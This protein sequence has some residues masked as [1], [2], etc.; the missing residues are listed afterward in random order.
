MKKHIAILYALL[1]LAA[2]SAFGQVSL[3]I[4]GKAVQ[5]ASITITTDTV[6]PPP[7]CP[8]NQV[9]TGTVCA[10]PQGTW[11]GSSCIV[12]PPPTGYMVLPAYQITWPAGNGYNTTGAPSLTQAAKTIQPYRISYAELMS[13]TLSYVQ[14]YSNTGNLSFNISATPGEMGPQGGVNPWI[15]ANSGGDTMKFVANSHPATDQQLSVAG[16]KRLPVF[17]SGIA[18]INVQAEGPA[19]YYLLHFH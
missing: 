8:G 12:T 16:A 10:C 5:K 19:G 6:T 15:L 9:W 2:V 14:L 11:N 1:L 17:Q 7:T 3:T 18:Y 13:G 4:D